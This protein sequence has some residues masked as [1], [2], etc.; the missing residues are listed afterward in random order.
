MW[1]TLFNVSTIII[2]SLIGGSL[3]ERFPVRFQTILLQAMGLVA[4]AIGLHTTVVNLEKSQYPIVFILSLAIGAVI[5]ES[6]QIQQR[7]NSKI[8]QGTNGS[9]ASGLTTAVL[10]FCIG[11]LSILGPIQAAINHDY[12]FLITNGVLDGITSIVLAATFGFGIMWAA[13]VLFIW[14]GS[15]YLVAFLFQQSLDPTLFVEPMIIGGIL[16]F[17][18]GLAIL[19]IKE[20]PTLNLLPGLFVSMIITVF[21]SITLGL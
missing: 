21:L 7:M 14:Q 11:S 5:G 13:L 9:L 2:G 3:R 18:S 1:G 8:D 12:T 6:L 15:I 17:A 20:L 19:K 10:L 4:I 16:I